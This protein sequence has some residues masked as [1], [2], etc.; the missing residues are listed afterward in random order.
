MEEKESKDNE[1]DEEVTDKSQKPNSSRYEKKF[2][3]RLLNDYGWLKHDNEKGMLC[4]LCIRFGKQSS[5]TTGCTNFRTSS[6][7]RH[8]ESSEHR[9]ALLAS[10]MQ[11]DLKRAM[12]RALTHQE[13]AITTAQ[14]TAYWLAKENVAT[15]KFGSLMKLLRQAGCP[16]V[17]KLDCGENA[18]Y[19]SNQAAEEFQDAC[20][21]IAKEIERQIQQSRC[22]S[23]LVDESID[24]SVTQKLV[25]YVRFMTEDFVHATRFVKN[26]NL[27]DGKATAILNCFKTVPKENHVPPPVLSKVFGLGSD[28]ASVMT[29][30]KGG[31]SALMKKENPM[32]VNVH[33]LAHRL[34]LCTSQAASDIAKLKN[35]QQ[36]ITDIYYYFSK[37]AKSSQGLKKVQEVLESDVLEGLP[38]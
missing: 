23:V 15:R 28:G 36:I 29:G 11:T 31:V 19:M 17:D 22:V 34:A 20:A 1:S 24:I 10:N 9:N 6:L 2:N 5:F 13:E 35:Y 4:E 30:H 8:A 32:L 3:T 18:K 21:V 12:A 14:K 16:N 26:P 25:V 33:C 37:S 38:P 27:S 7:T